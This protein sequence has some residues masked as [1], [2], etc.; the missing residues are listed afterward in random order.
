M[1]YIIIID[2]PFRGFNGDRT[3]RRL[4]TS[5]VFSDYEEAS[6][7]VSQLLQETSKFNPEIVAST[8]QLPGNIAHMANTYEELV[9]LLAELRDSIRHAN[10]CKGHLAYPCTC[11]ADRLWEE[12]GRVLDKARNVEEDA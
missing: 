4:A 5:H 12:S 3:K 11:D 10:H 7:H 6:A 9:K 8:H 2:T 1:Q